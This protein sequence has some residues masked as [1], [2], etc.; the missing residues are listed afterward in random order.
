MRAALLIAGHHLR[1]LARSPGLV[2]LLAAIPITLALIEYA[3]FGPTAASGKFPPVKVLTLDEDNTFASRMVPQFFAGGPM[4][5]YFELSPA[6]SREEARQLFQH[7]AAS[8]LIVVPGG[9]QDAL[10]SGR[11]AELQLYRN[12]IQT[13][14]PAIVDSVL[15]MGAAIGNGLLAQ[16]GEPL[17]R[18]KE[19]FA[20][21]KQPAEEDI[22]AVS[23][24]FYRAG[25]RF[26]RLGALQD[27]SVTIQ[28]PAG[29]AAAGIGSDPRQFFAFMFPGLVLFG[30][31]FI[32]EAL[33]MRLLRDR[34]RGLQRRLMATPASRGAVLGG[35]VLYLVSGLLVLLLLL[36]A[37]GSA[38]FRIELR[39]PAALLVL[40]LGFA[41]FAA[42]LQLLMAGLARSDRGAQAVSS[43]VIMVL[44]LLGGTF[45]PAE[46]YPPF[47]RSLAYALPNGATQQ[48][49]VDVLI[50]QRALAGI[51]GRAAIVWAW[52][53]AT[54]AAAVLV[55]R[56]R[57]LVL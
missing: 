48:G 43:I 29:G 20:A 50:H 2:L 8:A 54:L 13:F 39:Q 6:Q 44:A 12:P 25:Q 33:A 16:A 10:L 30:L 38:I 49:M 24:G 35:G 55:E 19:L 40:G 51:A 52:S 14:S 11:K 15:Q 5:D 34:L 31:F 47:L 7:G 41:A 37:I 46:S 9:F 18:I 28:R 56:R 57:G 1:R 4:K 21:R 32:S 22:T 53:I 3:A 42:G 23:L 27:I 45:V 17:H 36:G 26:A